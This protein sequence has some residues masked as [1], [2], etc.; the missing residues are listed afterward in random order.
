[1]RLFPGQNLNQISMQ[2]F[3]KLAKSIFFKIILAFVALSFVL[4][5]V[6]SFILGSPNTWVAKIGGDTI[7]YGQFNSALRADR[8]IILASSNKSEEALQ[9]LESERFKSDVLGRLVNQVMIKKLADD[10]DVSASKK[11][12]LESIARDPSFKNESGK[13]DR[14]KFEAFLKKNGL[15]EEKYV[16]EITNGI[17]A[18]MILQS[19]AVS[20]PMSDSVIAQVENFKQEKRVADV[21]T[22]SSKNVGNI[23]K[24]SEEELQK[25]FTENQT[26]Y[27]LP[28]RRKVSY[29]SFS[30]KDFAK[31]LQ[32]SDQEI[33][34]EYENGKEQ[35]TKS[36]TRNFYHVVFD[37]EIEAK[38]FLQKFEEFAQVD[39]LKVQIEFEKLAKELAKKDLKA[40]TLSKVLQKDLIPQIAEPIFK[41]AVNENSQVIASP[42]GF[43]V[44][45]LNE[46]AQPQLIPFSEVKN[47]I[48]Q[49]MSEGREEKILQEK[50]SAIDDLL[51]TSNSLAEVAK[52]FGLKVTATSVVIDENSKNDKG[53]E[54][55]EIKSFDNFAKNS[56]ALKA[57]QTSKVFYA[58]NSEGFYALEVAEIIP[59][60]QRELVEVQS[61]VTADLLVVKL[62]EALGDLARK[63]GEEV[64]QN[65]NEVAKVAARY[66]LKLDKA[67]EFPRIFYLTFQGQQV[68]YQDQFLKDLFAI[69]VDQ[70][71]PLATQGES[72][73]VI[74]VLREIKKSAVNSIQLEQAKKQSAEEFRKEV[75]SDYNAY[76]LARYPVKTNDKIFAKQEEK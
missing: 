18:T 15:N 22:I 57:K 52:K 64:K 39:K 24:P 32:I 42:L 10:F 35:Y 66:R 54:V 49:K 3:R 69:T 29:L 65:P 27:V 7:S 30:K 31:D 40:I 73:F 19:I 61:R 74:G 36:E 20:A 58:K 44:F 63:V 23:A 4:F 17:A 11:I 48:K 26:Q 9:Y 59:S 55:S 8:E 5:G 1:M 45:L 14:K 60:K 76:L 43:H 56:F 51:L 12:I 33:F 53:E 38:N 62:K 37:K 34:A 25:F 2:F 46:I 13:F 50:I 16:S 47:G 75:M 21:I 28:E 70:A 68:P 72:E 41:L 71:T 6:S 67:R